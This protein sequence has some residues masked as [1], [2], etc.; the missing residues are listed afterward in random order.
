[1]GK[2]YLMRRILSG[3]A[4][5]TLFVEAARMENSEFDEMDIVEDILCL[6]GP[7]IKIS[8]SEDIYT[9]IK[10]CFTYIRITL[11][12][13][14]DRRKFLCYIIA[15]CRNQCSPRLRFTLNVMRGR[16]SLENIK[17]TKNTNT[18]QYM[19]ANKVLSD[20][21]FDSI[22][23]NASVLGL[24]ATE[25]CYSLAMIDEL[26]G[27]KIHEQRFLELI[28][29]GFGYAAEAQFRT[30][31]E[32]FIFTNSLARLVFGDDYLELLNVPK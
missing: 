30:F 4:D 29:F 6:F 15:I 22:I 16:V 14:F 24:K 17:P 8:K 9:I 26:I 28:K 31:Y 2:N 7:R 25:Y 1:M 5:A 20:F 23:K 11:K 21:L 10:L 18:V 32:R 3:K 19:K 13:D 12:N 27:E